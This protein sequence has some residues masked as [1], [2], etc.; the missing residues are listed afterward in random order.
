MKRSYNKLKHEEGKGTLLTPPPIIKAGQ[1]LQAK[2]GI[3]CRY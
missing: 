2:L 3:K 1:V